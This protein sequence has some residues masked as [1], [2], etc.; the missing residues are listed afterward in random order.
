[1]STRAAAAPS[2]WTPVSC[3]SVAAAP[4]RT[5][6][7][8]AGKL[9]GDVADSNEPFRMRFVSFV[10]AATAREARAAGAA[11]P[12]IVKKSADEPIAPSADTARILYCAFGGAWLCGTPTVQS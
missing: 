4:G 5:L 8:H 11:S 7:V 6:K 3:V 12:A 10:A 2:I 1:M 9:F